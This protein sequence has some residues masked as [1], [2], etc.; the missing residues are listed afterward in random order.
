MCVCA[1][2]CV[3]LSPTQNTC[4]FTECIKLV[5]VCVCVCACVRACVR[6]ASAKNPVR[7]PR[8][9]KAAEGPAIRRADGVFLAGSDAVSLH[10]SEGQ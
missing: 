5:C 6:A 3:C 4:L 9:E 8:A 1:R 7:A 10:S 2:A